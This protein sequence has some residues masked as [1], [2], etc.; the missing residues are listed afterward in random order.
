MRKR[1][2]IPEHFILSFFANFFITFFNVQKKK[3]EK[4]TIKP[5]NESKKNNTQTRNK[6]MKCPLVVR[7]IIL[8]HVIVFIAFVVLYVFEDKCMYKIVDS[9]RGLLCGD[10]LLQQQNYL[11]AIRSA[12]ANG[13]SKVQTIKV[14]VEDEKESSNNDD[15]ND[16]KDNNDD[17]DNSANETSD[18][19][20]NNNN[21]E[22]DK[23]R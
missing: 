11:V 16:N 10:L 22:K 12:D 6:S 13:E 14:D 19:D 20:N 15:D 18:S 17:N 4:R 9:F 3:V 1:K 5:P 8:E 7:T 23:D 21:D 2:V